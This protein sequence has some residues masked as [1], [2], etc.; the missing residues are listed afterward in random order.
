M[1]WCLMKALKVADHLA[2]MIDKKKSGEHAK[3][4]G[5][6]VQPKGPEPMQKEGS[7]QE[8]KSELHQSD[9]S[10]L[11]GVLCP[12]CQEKVRHHMSARQSLPTEPGQA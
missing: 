5:S 12:A 9:I 1:Y 6:E 10:S 7:L 2:R 4:E 8:E 11:E 3:P